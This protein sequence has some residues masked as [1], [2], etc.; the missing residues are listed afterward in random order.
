MSPNDKNLLHVLGSRLGKPTHHNADDADVLAPAI[1]H[2]TV[3][4][5]L[6]RP[7]PSPA[8]LRATMGPHSENKMFLLEFL[9]E[10]GH[11]GTTNTPPKN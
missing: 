9:G 10:G 3:N 4:G 8:L 11:F 1:E 6:R 2:D 5:S 7:Q